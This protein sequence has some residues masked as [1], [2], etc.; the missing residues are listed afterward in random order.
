MPKRD[1]VRP[2]LDRDF[3]IRERLKAEAS[4]MSYEAIAERETARLAKLGLDHIVV[5]RNSIASLI[6]DLGDGKTEIDQPRFLR[7][8]LH[9][10]EPANG[11]IA[12]YN[13]ALELVR[14]GVMV[15]NDVHL[16]FTNWGMVEKALAVAE[17]MKIKTLIIAGDLLDVL[18]F[19]RFSHV[20]P[21]IDFETEVES[22][23]FFMNLIGEVFDEIYYFRGNHEDRIVKNALNGQVQFADLLRTI[24]TDAVRGKITWS[25]YDYLWLTWNRQ[26][27]LVCHQ[28]NTSVHKLSAAEWL[29]WKHGV[30]VCTTHAHK[31]GIGTDRFNRHIVIASGGLHDREKIAYER[32]K[33]NKGPAHETGFVTFDNGLVKLWTENPTIT[34]WSIIN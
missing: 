14:D 21:P 9:D 34:D 28:D 11:G 5:G 18:V 30:N 2:Y 7:T 20:V 16:P 26:R 10:V 6:R 17:A 3:I 1:K 25:N 13:G 32:M 15:M 27:W 24:E 31:N 12:V 33:T 22:A 19:G 4:R 29:S 8:Y 23:H